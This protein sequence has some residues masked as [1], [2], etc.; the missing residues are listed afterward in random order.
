MRLTTGL[1]K[2]FDRKMNN[3]RFKNIASAF[4]IF[5]AFAVQST[6][7]TIDPQ[8]L[9]F[10]TDKWVTNQLKNLTLDEKIAQLM[11][12]A[13]YPDLGMASKNRSLEIIQKYKPGGILVMKGNPLETATWINAFQKAS[14]TPLLVAIDGEWGLPMRIDS[15][16]RY[17]Y[18]QA[19]GAVT[20]SVLI[21]QMGRD[22]A[23]QMKL[24]GIQ[25]NFAPV[26][27][28]SSNPENPVINFR[29]FGENKNTVTQ[30]AWYMAKG[31]QD[32][33]VLP[34]AK[35]FPGHGNTE[36]DSHHT[37]PLLNH[38]KTHIDTLESFPFRILARNGIGG[39]MIGHLNVP[40][41]DKSETPSSL[42]NEIISGYLRNEIGYNGFVVTDA[43]DMKGVRTG[44]GNPEARSLIAG[45]DMVTCVS[46]MQKA[47]NSV[48]SAIDLGK[49]NVKTIDEKC[50]R[51]LAVKC[52]SGLNQYKPVDTQ[53]LYL[54]LNYPL[55][56]LTNRK[57]IKNSITVLKNK[58]I[59]PVQGLDTLKIATLNIG[60]NEVSTFQD[61]T[62]KYTKVDHFVLPKNSPLQT[63]VEIQEKLK[64]YNLIIAGIQG[65]SIYPANNFG[66]SATQQKAV[67][68]LSNENRVVFAFFGNA[69]ALR[70]FT[71]I[72]NSSALVV[73]YQNTAL[74]QEL[75]AQLIF[76]AFGSA[77]KLPV[78]IDSRFRLHE[79]II[80]IPN[81]TLAYTLPEEVGIRSD[82]LN[83]K[84]DSIV[85]LGLSEKAFPGCQVLVAKNGNV[86]FQKSYGWHTYEQKIKVQ[87]SDLYDWASVTK[88]TGPLPA[89]MQMVDMGKLDVEK[90]LSDYWPGF[91]NSNK[92]GIT[93]REF[94]AHQSGIAAWLPFWQMATGKRGELRSVNFRSQP[95]DSFQVRV[96]E[97][98]YLRNSYRQAIF[99]TIRNS[100]LGEKKYLYSDLSFHIYPEVITILSGQ[101]YEDFVRNRFYL[102]LGAT[103]VT[104]NPYLHF[105]HTQIVPTETDELFRMQNIHGFVHDEGAAMLGGISGNAGLFGCAGDLAKIFQMYLQKGYFGGKRYISEETITRFNQVQFPENNNRRAL[106]FDKP[107]ISNKTE[108]P[109][110]SY[111]AADASENS[112][113]HTGF[114]G[115]MV[116]ADPDNGLLF[117]FLSNRVHPTRENNKISDLNIRVGLHQAIY[118]CVNSGLH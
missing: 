31:M 89:L 25:V 78:T 37:L 22:I 24:M 70:H 8:F 42:S 57:L 36:T 19:L 28:I 56:K 113:G 21:Y 101:R 74:T 84:I 11:T 60:G 6:A 110:N 99:D 58:N 116:W 77:G 83:F 16:V 48:K 46:D 90:P 114:T 108:S 112:F 4:L 79:G 98:L 51:V 67:L 118:D 107:L 12:I 40:A 20:D 18:A 35:H 72:Q 29:S 64:S 105:G 69:Y 92:Q 33:G 87:N 61:F 68:D 102:P 1:E 103:T 43:I 100:K 63:W 85:N 34:V 71:N 65:I 106:G 59:L 93:I 50:K 82:L 17:P 75:A 13:V 30:N 96:S 9:K 111:P 81:K 86:I 115:N 14:K 52:W 27:D 53:N 15:T 62:S 44:E 45:V 88:V 39:I 10:K 47:I 109:T 91:K 55:F 94:L 95:S 54:K 26:A 2:I 32:E 5:V 38:S 3:T 76:G 97:N 80:T 66:I 7:Q 49:I 104:Y 117:V 23:Q 41:L 73:T